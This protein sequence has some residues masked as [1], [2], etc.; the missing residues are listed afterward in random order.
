MIYEL[1]EYTA[2]P[3]TVDK[4]HQRFA[5]NTLTLFAEHGIRPIGFWTDTEE[6]ARIVYLLQFADEQAQKQAWAGFQA[7]TRW[8]QVKQDSESDGPLV[9]SMTSRTLAPV[10]Y[11][12]TGEHDH[13]GVTR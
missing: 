3:G 7:D 2:H 5:E 11:W 12:P 9:S 1:R 6:P 10:G 13:D 8:Q 4:L